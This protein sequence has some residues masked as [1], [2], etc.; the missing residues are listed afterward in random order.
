MNPNVQ[1]MPSPVTAPLHDPLLPTVTVQLDRPR[2]LLVNFNALALLEDRTG[3]SVMQRESWASMKLSDVRLM[4]F[5]A[6]QTDDPTI[7]EKQVGRMLNMGN[8]QYVV[9]QITQ[10]WVKGMQG[11]DDD[12][13]AVG[14]NKRFRTLEILAQA[15]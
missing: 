8:L 5:A 14:E 2:K 1:T 10:A 15:A 11:E 6:L 7:T 3:R 12:A 13:Q 4:L 9:Q